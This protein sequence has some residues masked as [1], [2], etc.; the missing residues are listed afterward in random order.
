MKLPFDPK[1]RPLRLMLA[2]PG[3]VALLLYARAI[4]NGFALDD[5]TDLLQ[6]RFVTGPFD[7]VGI[8]T[9]EY[10]GGL[11]HLASG[12]YRPLLVLTYKMIAGEFGLR[13]MAFHLFN[14]L[15]FA[16]IVTLTVLLVRRLSGDPVMGV[17]A[18][19]IFAVHP[20]NTESV[21]AIVGLKDLASTALGILALTL[22]MRWRTA[23]GFATKPGLLAPAVTI[24]LVMLAGSLYKETAFVF[25]PL[26]VAVEFLCHDAPAAPDPRTRL[27]RA[28]MAWPF[29]AAAAAALALRAAVTGGLFRPSNVWSIDNPLILLPPGQRFIAALSLVGRY[30][31]IYLW[32]ACLAGDYSEGAFRLS[33][34]LADPWALASILLIL[35]AAISWAWA[36]IRGWRTLAFGLIGLALTYIL[37]SNL[38][39]TIGT[40]L[41]ERL[42]FACS[43]SLAI[44]L[45]AML[46][47]A[48]RR[49]AGSLRAAS[50][51][52]LIPPILLGLVLATLAVRTW[53]RIGDWKND[54]TLMHSSARCQP[55]NVKVLLSLADS[56]E[57]HGLYERARALYERAVSIRPDSP[58][59]R[60]QLGLFLCNQ[61]EYGK[62]EVLLREAAW[63]P[64]PMA[65]AVLSLANLYLDQGRLDDALRAAGRVFEAYPSFEDAA[66]ARSLRAEI[67]LQKGDMG[68]VEKECRLALAEDPEDPRAHYNLG[69]CLESRGD[70]TGALE[71]YR[72]SD[73][74]LPGQ[75]VVL[76][77]V[78]KAAFALGRVE[79]SLQTIARVR[80]EF[81][82]FIPG[83]EQAAASLFA[84]GR[85]QD[86]VEEARLLLSSA[87]DN[88]TGHLILG[89]VAEK[90]GEAAE[91]RRHFDA[92]LAR[93]DLRKDIAE[94]LRRRVGGPPE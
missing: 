57:Q 12:H 50:W 16:L 27:L 1:E 3:I 94:D 46:V 18:G 21:A 86:A 66:T 31:K 32:P 82:S 74:L 19:L 7:P 72:R 49:L 78:A 83:M 62:A 91:A 5:K 60:A 52:R 24:S 70:W 20:I 42:F 17:V 34:S 14:V 35:A 40:I 54:L 2:A 10:F 88:M 4:G 11:G 28:A 37:I 87:P 89:E 85:V 36:I 30:A 77:A 59:P 56:A 33:T 47:P 84:A 90:A 45:A 67:M 55:R 79:E 81:P 29:A 76:V 9:T 65:F 8:F 23:D 69:L 6:N 73:Q 38:V 75:A 92:I 39:V 53:A 26:A 48:G 22:Y 51:T 25:L 44:V 71:Q 58:I 43:W 63:S 13:P 80:R 68:A 61:K 93:P 41:A 64:E 15:V